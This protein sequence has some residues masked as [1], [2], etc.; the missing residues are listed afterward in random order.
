K[1]VAPYGLGAEVEQLRRE[2]EA[3]LARHSI[4][5]DDCKFAELGKRER[6]EVEKVLAKQTGQVPRRSLDGF[7]GRIRLCEPLPNGNQY[8]QISDGRQFCLVPA[9]KNVR[10]L[11]GQRV[12][13][14]FEG[15]KL[16]VEK[17][18]LGRE[19]E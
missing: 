3:F 14:G 10:S 12:R 1:S 18:K 8:A 7:E 15:K 13:I 5:L 2:R 17:R 9:D 16:K 11:T 4:A 6:E 19:I